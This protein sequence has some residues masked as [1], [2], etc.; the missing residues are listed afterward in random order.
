[1]L[2][3]LDIPHSI[4]THPQSSICWL[5][6][7]RLK[8]LVSNCGSPKCN[9]NLHRKFTCFY[10]CNLLAQE[11]YHHQHSLNIIWLKINVTIPKTIRNLVLARTISIPFFI[12]NSNTLSQHPHPSPSPLL[13]V[14]SPSLAFLPNHPPPLGV[15][16]SCPHALASHVLSCRGH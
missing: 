2:Y 3:I 10:L 8:D 1:M 12:L 6:E 14:C 13:P 11:I 15:D 5:Q 7:T 16:G 4:S 9:F